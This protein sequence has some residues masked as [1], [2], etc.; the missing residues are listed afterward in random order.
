[1]MNKIIVK[2]E[3][4]IIEPDLNVTGEEPTSIVFQNKPK[5]EATTQNET[6]ED[7]SITK[8][9]VSIFELPETNEPYPYFYH[10][11]N[12]LLLCNLNDVSETFNTDISNKENANI[13]VFNNELNDFKKQHEEYGNSLQNYYNISE[14]L[15]RS[16]TNISNELGEQVRIKINELTPIYIQKCENIMSTLLFMT[17]D[18]CHDFRGGRTSGSGSWVTDTKKGQL[19]NIVNTSLL[20][21]EIGITDNIYT[22][23]FMNTLVKTSFSG[24]KN[25][26]GLMVISEESYQ[27]LINNNEY[28][29]EINGKK[30]I[31]IQQIMNNFGNFIYIGSDIQMNCNTAGNELKITLD[32]KEVNVSFL[33]FTSDGW[34]KGMHKVWYMNEKKHIYSISIDSIKQIGNNITTTY[35]GNKITVFENIVPSYELLYNSKDK[36]GGFINNF[37]FNGSLITKNNF[38]EIYIDKNF[39]TLFQ[40]FMETIYQEKKIVEEQTEDNYIG[41]YLNQNG[42]GNNNNKL[43]RGAAYKFY[44]VRGPDSK[45]LETLSSEKRILYDVYENI[46]VELLKKISKNTISPEIHPEFKYPETFNFSKEEQINT[47]IEKVNKL[48]KNSLS[49]DKFIK[50]QFGTVNDM[51]IAPVIERVMNSL[52]CSNNCGI[53]NEE[54][55]IEEENTENIKKKNITSSPITTIATDNTDNSETSDNIE[56][57]LLGG[58]VR[59]S[60]ETK[61]SNQ[62]CVEKINENIRNNLNDS[63]P[64]K[65]QVVSGVLDSSLQGGENIPEYFPPELDI[66]MTIFGNDGKLLGAIVRMTFLKEILKNTTNTK[67]NARVFSHFIYVSYSEIKIDNS[68]LSDENW[69]MDNTKYPNALKLLLDYVVENTVLLPNLNNYLSNF[70]LKLKDDSYRRWYYYFS[71]TAGPSVAEGINEVIIKIFNGKLDSISDDNVD[72]SESIVKVSQ[73]IYEDSS[74]LREIFITVKPDKKRNYAFSSIFLLRIKY[75]GDKSRCT[76]SLFLNRNKY[77]ECLQVTGDENAYFTGLINGASTIF[78]PP[79]KFAIYFAPYFTYGDVEEGK[80]LINESVYK[81]TLLKGLSPTDFKISSSSTRKKSSEQIIEFKSFYLKANNKLDGFNTLQ[82]NLIGNTYNNQIRNLD[83]SFT[84]SLFYIQDF[85]GDKTYIEN[86]LNSKDYTTFTSKD[87][88]KEKNELEKMNNKLKKIN[89][90]FLTY[91]KC[92]E[93][94]LSIKYFIKLQVEVCENQI[95]DLK[96]SLNENEREILS[97]YSDKIMEQLKQVIENP[98]KDYRYNITL[99]LDDFDY[100]KKQLQIIF[101]YSK[102]IS[103]LLNSMVS[104]EE[105]DNILTNI[106]DEA[107]PFPKEAIFYVHFVLSLNDVTSI[108]LP[109]LNKMLYR[110]KSNETKYEDNNSFTNVKK[111][112]DEI[113]IDIKEKIQD[114]NN[115]FKEN[116]GDVTLPCKNIEEMDLKNLRKYSKNLKL[117]D[118]GSK[119]DLKTQLKEKIISIDSDRKTITS[120]S[121]ISNP[122]KDNKPNDDITF[123]SVLEKRPSIMSA[124]KVSRPKIE[125]GGD[126]Q[127]NRK[128]DNIYNNELEESDSITKYNVEKESK[129]IPYES[130]NDNNYNESYR[131]NQIYI[132]KCFSEIIKNNNELYNVFIIKNKDDINI[133]FDVMESI[134]NYC[135]SILMM[136]VYYFLTGFNPV[137]E[138][139][140]EITKEIDSLNIETSS[141]NDT[142]KIRNYYSEIINTFID[143]EYLS[144]NATTF[145]LDY[146]S[147]QIIDKIGFVYDLKKWCEINYYLLLYIY[148]NLN[149]IH[150]GKNKFIDDNDSTNFAIITTIY[151]F[152]NTTD[153]IE[154]NIYDGLSDNKKKVESNVSLETEEERKNMEKSIK[155]VESYKY[156]SLFLIKYCNEL[157]NKISNNKLT[158]SNNGILFDYNIIINTLNDNESTELLNTFQNL[159]VNISNTSEIQSVLKNLLSLDKFDE[160]SIVIENFKNDVK[161]L[162]NTDLNNKYSIEEANKVIG[163]G[164]TLKNKKN[165]RRNKTRNSKKSTHK[166]KTKKRI[167]SKQRKFTRRR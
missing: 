64:F 42:S 40:S 151:N 87:L 73:K 108:I 97:K 6:I 45:E 119:D 44:G 99:S 33:G 28:S 121:S 25:V 21:S 46:F 67:N 142:I 154:M 31:N 83:Y 96:T 53:N 144:P 19:S 89:E 100:I 39:E 135:I 79:S 134:D 160:Y 20:N 122:L 125:I 88:C 41:G 150:T 118:K 23:E 38:N 69:Q 63:Y 16:E 116:Y 82:T 126:A 123:T 14:Q 2:R 52:N 76:D 26:V 133:N 12:K 43:I 86:F 113:I 102:K 36:E 72:I 37:Q 130:N 11:W 13:Y 29:L 5:L 90:N 127:M 65:F 54:E 129:I 164:I 115:I 57:S 161:L 93:D 147:V 98:D 110:I 32:S 153:L 56:N 120:T 27:I 132:L 158:Y 70:E 22:N 58:A 1:M 49:E 78:S 167:N 159:Q 128:E 80:F 117:S 81:E 34:D 155:C 163:A 66:F 55:E 50:K 114:I 111:E 62:L 148:E 137:L 143:I 30:E 8:S 35:S 131:R 60:E 71:D 9:P 104:V 166:K 106:V 24:K 94:A 3:R 109:N 156:L 112:I 103:D 107:K 136:Q 124:I 61:L 77:L 157:A 75:I 59:K 17:L 18:Q 152:L 7:K 10:T 140:D 74:E 138:T 48:Y 105:L 85:E 4:P 101:N 15:T 146:Y 139:I 149:L 95:N 162:E 47:R 141:L 92:Y 165:K 145:I 68:E 84:S 51:N 91:N